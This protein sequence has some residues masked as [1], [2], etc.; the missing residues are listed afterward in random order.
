L[1]QRVLEVCEAAPACAAR[2]ALS[3]RRSHSVSIC[4]FVPVKQVN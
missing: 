1:L 4:T 3:S 2:A